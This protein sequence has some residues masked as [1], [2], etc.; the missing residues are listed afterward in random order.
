MAKLDLIEFM[1]LNYSAY[2]HNQPTHFHFN[3]RIKVG[4]L[5]GSFNPAHKGHLHISEVAKKKLNLNEIWWLVTPQNRLKE[6]NISKTYFQR[7]EEAKKLVS[8]F[9]YIKVLDYEYHFNLSHSYKSLFFLKKRS[10]IT[11]FVWIMGSDNIKNFPKWIRPNDIAKIFP[12]AVIERPSYS[13]CIFNSFGA[14]IL[15]SRLMSKRRLTMQKTPCWSYIKDRLNNLS[16]SK[17]RNSLI[18]TNL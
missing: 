18:P 2:R 7:L 17:I 3:R 11:K 12:I 4:I 10:R 9:K 6:D 13:Q 5:G 14:K 16:S 15:G 8:K 1:N